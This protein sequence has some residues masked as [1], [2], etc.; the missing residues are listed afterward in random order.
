[1]PSKWGLMMVLLP[2]PLFREAN[3][4]YLLILLFSNIK[5][6][7][8]FDCLMACFRLLKSTRSL[9]WLPAVDFRFNLFSEC[10]GPAEGPARFW[11]LLVDEAIRSPS[12]GIERAPLLA[13]LFSESG[14][15]DRASSLRPTWSHDSL[16]WWELW[17]L[18]VEDGLLFVVL[19]FKLFGWF[20]TET[21]APSLM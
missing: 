15:E 17:L 1:M 19:L 18:A 21:V 13:G 20:I 6:F 4:P 14:L 3:R 16:L 12:S 2:V 5:L 9:F 8:L 10:L 11:P 7:V